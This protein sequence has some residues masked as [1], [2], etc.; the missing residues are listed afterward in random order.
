[1]Y[2]ATYMSID[3]LNI[4]KTTGEFK[5]ERTEYKAIENFGTQLGFLPI[6]CI[7]IDSMKE[8]LF[9][10]VFTSCN[11]PQ[12]LVIFK[13]DNVKYIEFTNWMNYINGF[14]PKVKVFSS[15]TSNY[16]E[17]I[18]DKITLDSVLEVYEVSSRKLLDMDC[19]EDMINFIYSDNLIEILNR[20]CDDKGIKEYWLIDI[21]DLDSSTQDNFLSLITEI[22]ISG[23][24]LNEYTINEFKELVFNNIIES[25]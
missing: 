18:V 15:A 14:E 24:K 19:Q 10:F 6:F 17:G 12:R 1:M 23:L 7:P 22:N 13:S 16:N 25:I 21:N 2:F 3:D 8:T 20:Y 9:K 11:A 4:L 5:K